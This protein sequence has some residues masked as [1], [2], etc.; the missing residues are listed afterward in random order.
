[1]TDDDLDRELSRLMTVDPAPE[2]TARVRLAV[3]DAPPVPVWWTPG[4]WLGV[5]AA[6]AA[7]VVAFVVMGGSPDAPLPREAPRAADAEA[8]QPAPNPPRTP[9]SPVPSIEMP[10]AR[11]AT[12]PWGVVTR[13]ATRPPGGA[14]VYREVLVAPDDVRGMALLVASLHAG[15]LDTARMEDVPSVLNPGE[16]PMVLAV[17][18]ADTIDPLTVVPIAA[19]PLEQG[20]MP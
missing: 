8:G 10:P 19:L 17:A 3:A 13:A 20:V 16:V 4:A 6:V 12:A 11:T 5:S 2:F 15:D 1:M 18:P 14:P 9:V 7:I